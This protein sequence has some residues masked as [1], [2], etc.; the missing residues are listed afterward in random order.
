MT[1][2]HTG[3]SEGYILGFVR[4]KSTDVSEERTA[5]IFMI[6]GHAKQAASKWLPPS[7]Y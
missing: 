4:Q 7:P 1:G 5:S 3:D 2:H 6:E